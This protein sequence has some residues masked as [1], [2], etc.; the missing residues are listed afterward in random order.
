MADR[1][2]KRDVKPF[3]IKFNLQELYDK[4][5]GTYKFKGVDGTAIL[6]IDPVAGTLT[7]G[8]DLTITTALTVTGNF[9]AT[10]TNV[11]NYHVLE[12]TGYGSEQTTGGTASAAT[13]DAA[14]EDA[15]AAFDNNFNTKWVAT[16]DADSWLK[17]QFTSAKTIT[18]YVLTTGNDAPDR[19]PN[20]WTFEGSNN[21]SDWTVIDTQTNTALVGIGVK[22][23][24]Y[25][26]DNATA[27]TFYRIDITAN[28]GSADSQLAEFE[29]YEDA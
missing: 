10:G 18:K 19:H 9:T 7:L 25:V 21:D 22:Y 17:Y 14:P 15:A 13:E 5:D 1:I 29:M 11:I 8:A 6:T 23:T 24:F 12:E 16:G 28:N 2:K 3:E 26:P 27:Y 4:T 20:T